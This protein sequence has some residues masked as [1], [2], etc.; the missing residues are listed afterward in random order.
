MTCTRPR[1]S[2]RRRWP[3]STCAGTGGSAAGSTTRRRTP[4]PRWSA[5]SSARGGGARP[6]SCRTP[7]RPTASH[8]DSA[9]DDRPAAAG[10]RGARR[11]RARRPG[12]A[13]A[14][15]PEDRSVE[16]RGPAA[17]RE[18]GRGPQPEHARPRPG[19]TAPHHPSHD[20][21]TQMTDTQVGE[22]LERATADLHPAPT[23]WPAGIAA[24][25]GVAGAAAV[26]VIAAG[27][28][29]AAAVGGAALALPGSGPAPTSTVVTDPSGSTGG[30]SSYARAQ[31]SAPPAPQVDPERRAVPGGC[32]TRWPRRSRP[33]ERRGDEPGRR[34]VPPSGPDG[35]Q[36]G[37][38]DLDGGSVSVSYQHST[39]PR[40]DGDL[41]A[42]TPA[43]RRWVTASSSST[44]SARV[45]SVAKGS[46]A[47]A[48]SASPTT[49]P[50]AT[51]ST[52]RP[53]N[54]SSTDPTEPTRDEPVLDLDALTAIA[55][56]PVWR[57]VAGQCTPVP[58]GPLDQRPG[59]PP[60]LADQVE[61]L[62]RCGSPARSR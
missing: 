40:C 38:V 22:L 9:A 36:S 29:A 59:G 49:R 52:R 37:A 26:A 24:G 57:A 8:P 47:S 55:E 19:A 15:L 35:W 27:A 10:R 6:A 60:V 33:C 34:P 61:Q 13:G 56:N 16:R 43:A 28:L 32:P 18:R 21:R 1:T 46:P 44:Y 7:S 54:G 58:L 23:S 42:G 48:T 41:A 51:R 45:T 3:R 2:S 62:R 20:R 14:A 25:A 4:R 11:A 30:A 5:P 39:G 31:P 17:R 50:T 12:G 53:S